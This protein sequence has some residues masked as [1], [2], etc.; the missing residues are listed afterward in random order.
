MTVDLETFHGKPLT[1]ANAS[2]DPFAS[3]GFALGVNDDHQGQLEQ[4]AASLWIPGKRRFLHTKSVITIISIIVMVIGC[5]IN[6]PL[7]SASSEQTAAE[8]WTAQDFR[9]PPRKILKTL[10]CSVDCRYFRSGN[11]R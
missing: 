3:R 9:T 7:G 6:F 11:V 1:R 10:I 2:A 4:P 5:I 8:K